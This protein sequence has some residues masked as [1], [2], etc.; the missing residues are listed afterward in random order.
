M[1]QCNFTLPF[2][3]APADVIHSVKTEIAK[4]GGNFDGNET[5]GSFSVSVFGSSI[6]GS[7]SVSG[8]SLNVI[9][10][11]K[12]IFVNCGQIESFMKGYIR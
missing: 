5:E 6:K 3:A 7:Y 8:S 11:S 9:I 12:P 1:A 2:S 10:D 4:Q